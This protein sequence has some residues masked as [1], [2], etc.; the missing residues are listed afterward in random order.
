[1]NILITESAKLV[2]YEEFT[3]KKGTHCVNLHFIAPLNKRDAHLMCSGNRAMSFFVPDNL[4]VKIS[5]ND[6]GEEFTIYTAFYGNR[7]NL[8]DIVK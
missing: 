5:A 7:M 8:L 1:M 2:G 6:V 3:S 4:K